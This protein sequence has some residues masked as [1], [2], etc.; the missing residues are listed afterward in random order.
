M[1]ESSAAPSPQTS[2]EDTVAWKPAGISLPGSGP[3]V[4]GLLPQVHT[5]QGPVGAPSGPG[6]ESKWLTKGL[7]SET[8]PFPGKGNT[9]MLLQEGLGAKPPRNQSS[10]SA[11]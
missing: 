10:F 8:Q 11:V 4:L 6:W 5:G 1:S 9:L 7:A 3:T 2:D